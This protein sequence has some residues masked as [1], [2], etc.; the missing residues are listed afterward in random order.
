[1]RRGLIAVGGLAGDLAGF[2]M[3]AGTI[4]FLK[5]TGIRHGAGMKRGTLA[6]FGDHRPELLPTF[7][8]ACRLQPQILPLVFQQLRRHGFPFPEQLI[9]AEVDVYNGDLVAG[10]RGEILIRA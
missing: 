4:L 8:R 1:M 5:G 9:A 7:R 2:N 3:L 6:F 10:G